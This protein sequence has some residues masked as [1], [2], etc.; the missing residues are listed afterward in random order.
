MSRAR[1]EHTGKVLR[2]ELREGNYGA[3]DLT[4]PILDRVHARRP[5]RSRAEQ[6]QAAAIRKL[7]G[8]LASAA[9][10]AIS[11]AIFAPEA[12]RSS[13]NLPSLASRTDAA[14]AATV[15]DEPAPMS[16]VPTR[17]EQAAAVAF[18]ERTVAI[19]RTIVNPSRN[20]PLGLGAATV[21][22]QIARTLSGAD[23]GPAAPR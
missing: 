16:I 6:Q 5:F 8:F 18:A 2:R 12:S 20:E 4:D 7:A 15:N 23:S 9:V 11:V 17:Q 10:V 22:D 1:F 13:R 14:P 19:A 3:P 21:T